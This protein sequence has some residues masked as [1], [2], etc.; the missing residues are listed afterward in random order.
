[1]QTG[2]GQDKTKT[3]K[4]KDIQKSIDEQKKAMAEQKK[5]QQDIEENLKQQQFEMQI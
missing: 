5:A 3:E 4:E 2:Y 1:M